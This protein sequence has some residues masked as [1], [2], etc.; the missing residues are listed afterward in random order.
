MAGQLHGLKK[1]YEKDTGKKDF[2][3]KLLPE[4]LKQM[5][6]GKDDALP[7]GWSVTVH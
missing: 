2:D 3:S 1:Q 5:G 6:D 4:T 7:S